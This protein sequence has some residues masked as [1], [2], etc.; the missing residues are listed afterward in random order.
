MKKNDRAL[1]ELQAMVGEWARRH[2][3]HT[4]YAAF[5]L[6][7]SEE[8]VTATL[9]CKFCAFHAV[10]THLQPLFE[11]V[12]KGDNTHHEKSIAPSQPM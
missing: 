9:G 4:F 7:S 3:V 10:V 5:R 1:A 6:E 2:D 12:L 8:I 11:E